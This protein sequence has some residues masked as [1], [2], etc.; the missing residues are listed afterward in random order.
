MLRFME[1]A[2]RKAAATPCLNHIRR[3]KE[4]YCNVRKFPQGVKSNPTKNELKEWFLCSFFEPHRNAFLTVGHKLETTTMDNICEFVR[5][6]HKEEFD[7]GTL[8]IKPVSHCKE[9]THERKI[10]GAHNHGVYH[11]GSDR[12]PYRR[13]TSHCRNDH[14]D[15][16]ARTMDVAG[17]IPLII[18][19]TIVRH[20]AINTV[21]TGVIIA[22]TT[23]VEPG[24]NST[25]KI[26]ATVESTSR[27]LM[28]TK[29]AT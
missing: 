16:I 13:S 14:R 15:H 27:V 5:L 6:C 9:D 20:A 7:N 12:K 19:K 29:I 26:N 17:I 22:R 18:V 11:R 8:N 28:S 23:V 24:R 25:A 10:R 4:I 3:F 21:T 2:C 1:Q